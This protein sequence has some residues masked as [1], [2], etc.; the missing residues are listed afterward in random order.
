MW[1]QDEYCD[2]VNNN[3]ACKFDGGAC[4]NNNFVNK[5]TYCHTCKECA[6]L[7]E[8]SKISNFNCV[9]AWIGDGFCDDV[10]NKAE[11]KFDFGDCCN[12]NN[13]GKHTY[14]D[15]CNECEI[16]NENPCV[17]SWFGDNYCDDYNNNEVCKFDNGDCCDLTNKI[18]DNPDKNKY[19]EFCR[20][21][22]ILDSD[23]VDSWNNDTF[24]DDYNN[25]ELCKF[26]GG[27]CCKNC[28]L[29]KKTLM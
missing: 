4:C 1:I 10:N 29:V 25:N 2:D 21:C 6:I 5:T 18:T 8:T 22:I 28:E 3:V 14:C 27:D 26:D 23:C 13:T 19:C 16:L 24:C 9:E 20:N 11:C 12:N 17:N 15:L 7:D